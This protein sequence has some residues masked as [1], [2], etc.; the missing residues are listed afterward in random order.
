MSPVGERVGLDRWY[1]WLLWAYPAWYRR[2]R[3]QEMLTTLLDAARPGQRRPTRREVL[4]LAVQGVRCRLRLPRGLGYRIVALIVVP[5]GALAGWAI[6]GGLAAGMLAAPPGEREAAEV[7]AAAVGQEP[8]NV[9]GPAYRCPDYCNHQWRRGGDAVVVF[10]DV[11]W[12][13]NGL[14]HTTVVYWDRDLAVPATIERARQW[15]AADG[16]SI[17]E[18]QFPPGASGPFGAPVEGFTGY[19]GGVAVHVHRQADAAP[20]LHLTFE[21]GRRPEALAA[22]AAGGAVGGL[23][24]GWATIAWVSQ[25]YRRHHAGTL[26]ATGVVVYNLPILVVMVLLEVL[27]AYLAVVF[28]SSPNSPAVLVPTLTMNLLS[29][30]WIPQLFAVGIVVGILVAARPAP[31]DLVPRPGSEVGALWQP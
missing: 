31:P 19:R 9:P 16:W 3:G 22:A 11:P 8:Y 14:D 6:A 10:D 21:P 27:T 12:R 23:V 1:R 13:N 24:A 4:D 20:P 2:E 18:R 7:A 28:S 29:V 30:L 17:D 26:R 5:F 15:L 25:R